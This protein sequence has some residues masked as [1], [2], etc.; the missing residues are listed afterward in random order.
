MHFNSLHPFLILAPVKFLLAAQSHSI[1][2]LSFDIPSEE[3]L[4]SLP[5]SSDGFIDYITYDRNNHIVYWTQRDPPAIWQSELNGD[6]CR[7]LITTNIALPEGLVISDSGTNLYWADSI[8][9]KI[10]VVSLSDGAFV[11]HQRH[12]LIDL[13]L[14]HP[15]GLAINESTG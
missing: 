7:P 5:I 10:E 15:I 1:S 14:E 3:Y 4:L 8:L 13:G 6:N 12:T 11:P 2:L 9:D